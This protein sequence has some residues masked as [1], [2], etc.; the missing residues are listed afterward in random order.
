MG[1]NPLKQMLIVHNV[2]GTI[3][4]DRTIIHNCNLWVW[5]GKQME[6]LGFYVANLDQDCTILG[7]PWFKRFNPSFVWDSNSLLEDIDMARYYTK[8]TTTLR[9]VEL[10]PEEVED[11]KSI[12]SQI[13]K[14]YHKYWEV[15][16]EQASYHFPPAHKEDHT[17]TLKKGIPDKIDCK[18]YWQTEEELAAMQQFITESLAKGYITNSKS[19]YALALFYWKKKDGKLHPI[20][21]YHILNQWTVHDNYLPLI[22]NIINHFQG[23]TLFS[24]FDICWGYNNIQIKEE[25]WWKVAFK[26]LFGLYEP[27]VMYLGL[28]NSLAMFYRAMQK[29]L[30]NWL[31]KYPD[32]TGNYIDDMVVATKGNSWRHQQIIWELL[33]IFQENSYFL[34][35][36]KCE[37]EVSSIECLGLVVDGTTLSINPKKVA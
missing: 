8:A 29:M 9:A 35:P 1:I 27:T 26:T 7:Y 32:E 13:P 21:D 12:Q 16:S 25:D 24:K 14:A 31:N 11:R 6:K 33:D 22:N 2:N 18:I 37:F 36:A 10:K 28:T 20:M 5:R 19:P 3:N 23:K 4:W 30:H 17:I 34:H 15:F